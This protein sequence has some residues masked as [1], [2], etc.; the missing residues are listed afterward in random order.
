MESF[1]YWIGMVGI[2]AFSATAVL[3]VAEK[4]VDFFGATILGIITAVGGGTIRDIIMDQPVFWSIDVTYI[5]VAIGASAVVF[6]TESLFTRKE[7]Y[8]LMLYLDGFGIACGD[9]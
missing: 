8:A 4:S 3:A 2:F 9:A 7:I 5:W 1:N 6:W